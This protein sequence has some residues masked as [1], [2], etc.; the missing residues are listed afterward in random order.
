[1]IFEK[2]ITME[3]F[4]VFIML[5]LLS[6]VFDG[7]GPLVKQSDGFDG[8]LW[9]SESHCIGEDNMTDKQTAPKQIVH[10]KITC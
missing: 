2:T 3:Y 10:L 4:L 1:M 8:A 7:Y 5:P 6:M 9:S